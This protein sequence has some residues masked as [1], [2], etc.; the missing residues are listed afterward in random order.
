MAYVLGIVPFVVPFVVI[1]FINKR[2]DIKELGKILNWVGAVVLSIA[3][4]I[5]GGGVVSLVKGRGAGS[6][7]VLLGLLMSAVAIVLIYLST[8]GKI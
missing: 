3:L 5:L 2:E 1:H 7:M 4:F 8:N 6:F